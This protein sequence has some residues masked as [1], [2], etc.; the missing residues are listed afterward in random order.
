MVLEDS[1]VGRRLRGEAEK[2]L[3]GGGSFS[4]ERG[5]GRVGGGTEPCREKRSCR[6]WLGL[7]ADTSVPPAPR[8]SLYS[9]RSWR[10]HDA[11]GFPGL[12]W[13][14]AGVPVH[15]GLGECPAAVRGPHIPLLQALPRHSPPLWGRTLLFLA[16]ASVLSLPVGDSMPGLCFSL[17]LGPHLLLFPEST[18]T[19]AFSFQNLMCYS[20]CSSVYS[21]LSSPRIP[22]GSESG[23]WYPSLTDSSLAP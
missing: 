6:N 13:G 15:A 3:E 14:R 18:S 1:Q 7:P 9:H 21:L 11:G 12:L 17:F 10:P 19:F 4:P 20:S 23:Q 5:A 16:G 22:V 2:L 8:R